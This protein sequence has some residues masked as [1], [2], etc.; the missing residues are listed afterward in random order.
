M[1]PPTNSKPVTAA[2]SGRRGRKPRPIENRPSALWSEWVDPESFAEALDL[3]MRRHGDTGYRLRKALSLKGPTVNVTTLGTWR[4][5][6][7]TPGDASSLRAL[8]QIEA[9]YDLPPGYFRAKIPSTGKAIANHCLPKLSAPERRHLTWHLPHDFNRL[10]KTKQEEIV[11]WVRRVII[12]GSTDYRR[13]QAAAARQRFSVRF[14]NAPGSVGAETTSR[15]AGPGPELASGTIAAPEALNEE[16]AS[17]LA[18]KTATL[19]ALGVQRSGV[20]GSET[21]SL[22]ADHL[23]LLFGALAAAPDSEIRGAGIP[24]Q[25]LT[26]ALLVIPSVWDWYLEWRRAKRGFYTGWEIEMLMLCGALTREGVGWLRQNPQL[27]QRLSPISGLISETEISEVRA[28]WSAACDGARRHALHR[29]KELSRLVTVHRDPFEPIL[30]IL[31][32][33]SPLNEYRKITEEIL[34]RAPNPRRYPV[35]AAE[36][37]RAFLMLRLGLHLGVRQKNLRQLLVCQSG[38]TPTPE[39][40]L[41]TMKCGELRW[42]E[43]ECHWEAFIP[44][45]AFKNSGSSYFS[46]QPFCLALRDFGGLYDQIKLYLNKHRSRLLGTMPDPGTFFVKTAK[47]NSKSAAYDQN[48]FYEAWRLAIQRYGI[49]NPYAGRGAIK[50][51][52]PHGPHNV[53]DVLATHVLKQTGSYE[54]ASYAIQDTPETVAKHYGRFLPRD[55]AALAAQVLNKVWEDA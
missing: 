23:G 41:E 48:T 40:R 10:P 11:S 30:A 39:R 45:S 5:G 12:S 15:E 14:S 34:R 29:A 37:C 2:K 26:F 1:A 9:R 43:R 27:A 18:F 55:K 20:W 17:L 21:A 38:S 4:R 25:Q 22:K 54:Q 44:A 46:R 7:K 53:R 24:L 49:F 36:A 31:E 28:D 52:L 8:E 35:P 51:L 3:H 13:Y 47:T 6:S 42:N 33:D 19:S 50:G 32:S 16:M